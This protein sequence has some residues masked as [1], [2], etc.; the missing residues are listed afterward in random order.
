[1]SLKTSS[2]RLADAITLLGRK[3][4]QARLAQA[5]PPFTIA[6]SREAG[7]NGHVIAYAVGAKLSW[8]VYDRELVQMLA[9]EMGVRPG[10]LEDLD[11]KR[12]SWLREC[13]AA[14]TSTHTVSQSGY[15]RH[16]VEALAALSA[17]GECVFVGRGA[18]Q[19]LPPATTLR[20]RLIAPQKARVAAIQQ[21]LGLSREEA[22]RW[23]ER[24]DLERSGF[25]TEHFHTDPADPRNYDLILNSARFSIEGAAQLVVEALHRLRAATM[26]RNPASQCPQEA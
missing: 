19:I 16:L 22:Q 4:D 25:V 20:V 10:L 17:H 11:E 23:I 1:M 3:Q 6:I 8:P 14:F 12:A 9:D 5:L 15:V 21:H 26:A 13:V 24:T 18:A 2:E 7:A